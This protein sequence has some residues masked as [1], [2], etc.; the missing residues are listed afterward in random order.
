MMINN[1]KWVKFKSKVSDHV[2]KGSVSITQAWWLMGESDK[3]MSRVDELEAQ[4]NDFSLTWEDREKLGQEKQN[5]LAKMGELA[6]RM[7]LE[8]GQ[9]KKDMDRDVELIEEYHEFDNPQNR[10][11]L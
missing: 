4:E 7:E 6:R 5:V 2:E 10:D 11:I 3:L 9:L 1:H 8:L